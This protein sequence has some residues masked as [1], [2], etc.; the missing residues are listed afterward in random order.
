M[1]DGFTP[2][3]R[4]K[5]RKSVGSELGPTALETGERSTEP[6]FHLIAV[7]VKLSSQRAADVFVPSP[8]AMPRGE[9]EEGR[10]I[11]WGYILREV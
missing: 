7:S 4:L 11:Y 5:G 2:H 1:F 3:V 8:P 10:G 9:G 6:T